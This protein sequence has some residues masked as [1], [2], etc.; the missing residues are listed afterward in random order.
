MTTPPALKTSCFSFPCFL[1]ETRADASR[2]GSL[3][4]SFDGF[5]SNLNVFLG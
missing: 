4:I 5:P 1:P 3:K 2:E